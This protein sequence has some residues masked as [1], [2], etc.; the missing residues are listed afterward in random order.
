MTFDV[1]VP[2]EMSICDTDGYVPFCQPATVTNSDQ[3]YTATVASGG[4]LTLPDTT[5]NVQID[6]TQVAT[7]TYATLSNQTLNL[8][9]Q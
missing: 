7:S 3:S 5:F 6:G 4:V 9:W 8:I 2:N 1:T